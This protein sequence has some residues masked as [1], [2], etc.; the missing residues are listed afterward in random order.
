MIYFE[1]LVLA[2]KH[3]FKSGAKEYLPYGIITQAK[4]VH[5]I[6]NQHSCDCKFLGLMLYMDVFSL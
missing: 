5:V 1:K 6:R 3:D 2:H 4:L